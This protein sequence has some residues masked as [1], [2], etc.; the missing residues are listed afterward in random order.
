MSHVLIL[1]AVTSMWGF[2]VTEEYRIVSADL[3]WKRFRDD[4]RLLNTLVVSEKFCHQS[5]NYN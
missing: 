4:I 5:R 3:I 1:G 2:R